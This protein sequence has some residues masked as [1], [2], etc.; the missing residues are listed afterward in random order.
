MA[1]S[2][3]CRYSL[4]N[5]K[6]GGESVKPRIQVEIRIVADSALGVASALE[7]L[8]DRIRARGKIDEDLGELEDPRLPGEYIGHSIE[9]TADDIREDIWGNAMEG[10]ENATD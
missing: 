2:T 7:E 3:C 8:V 4:S 9:Q 5:F 10:E 1:G 6:Q